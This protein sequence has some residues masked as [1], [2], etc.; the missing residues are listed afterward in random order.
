MCMN[1]RLL[2]RKKQKSPEN[3][4]YSMTRIKTLYWSH[5]QETI[6]WKHISLQFI[7]FPSQMVLKTQVPYISVIL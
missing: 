6:A 5:V 4:V 3:T 2:T 1:I 7:C